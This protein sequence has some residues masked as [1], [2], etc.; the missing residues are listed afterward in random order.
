MAK[1]RKR[2]K[3]AE[4]KYNSEDELTSEEESERDSSDDSYDR[5][6]E[7]IDENEMDGPAM[8][9]TYTQADI[10]Q[11]P[12]DVRRVLRQYSDIQ[13]Q[14]TRTGPPRRAPRERT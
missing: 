14:V 3:K 9:Y 10:D 7:D 12:L 6:D 1:Q 11:A 2:A 4:A 8:K 5:E 13:L